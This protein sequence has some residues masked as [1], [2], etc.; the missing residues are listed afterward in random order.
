MYLKKKRVCSGKK[1]R[2]EEG[3]KRKGK[4]KEKEVERRGRGG[5]DE[6]GR[7]GEGEEGEKNRKKRTKTDFGRPGASIAVFLKS[8]TLRSLKSFCIILSYFSGVTFLK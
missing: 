4:K 2:A 6:G 8:F 3:E 7:R 1:K 5:R